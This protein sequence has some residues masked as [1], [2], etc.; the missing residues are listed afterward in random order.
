[1]R[2]ALDL[3]AK[4]LGQTRPNP[5][6]GAVLVK[7]G[8][9]VGRGYHRT[10][11]LPHAEAVALRR[12]GS[13]AR[14]ATLYVNLEPCCHRGR[15]PPCVDRI[16]CAGVRRV[17]VAL[18]DP[19]PLVAGRGIRR[20]RA[21]GVQ[22]DVGLL[23]HEATHVNEP[24]LT[25]HRLG[26]PFFV[27]KWALTLDGR[28]AAVS[29]DSR[30]ITGGQSRAYVHEI[31]A[32]YDAVMVGIGTV[33]ADDPRLNVRLS[34]RRKVIQ[35]S[36]II[37]DSRLRTPLKARCLDPTDAG[38]TILVATDAAPKRRVE[39]FLRR[40]ATVLTVP[41]EKG[42]VDLT[43]LADRLHGLGIQSV[44]IEGGRQVLSSLFAADL[45]DRV[46]AFFAPKIVGGEEGQH[47]LAGWGV[48]TMK[49]AIP[50]QEVAI[51]HFGTDVCVEGYVHHGIGRASASGKRVRVSRKRTAGGARSQNWK[52]SC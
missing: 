33:L 27:A 37:V 49:Q 40:G 43:A 18:K 9:V 7:N 29:G 6:V 8:A 17:V 44:L 39:Q 14:G 2:L 5:A 21:A 31:R 28:F 34:G 25:F 26:R 24:F 47:V 13:A 42:I 3:A 50:L 36:R 51:R 16:K 23:A 32:R 20:L 46:V 52:E 30:W 45:V 38:P 4:G 15:T 22:V 11:G 1:M 41:G 12:A 35:P 10:A 48:R 19:N